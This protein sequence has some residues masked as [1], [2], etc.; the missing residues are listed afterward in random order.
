MANFSYVRDNDGN[1]MPPNIIELPVADSQTL[2]VGDAVVLSSNK[3]AK[4]STT[5]GSCVGIMAEAVTTGS[6]AGGPLA[7]VYVAKPSQIWRATASADATS[8]V[9]GAATFDLTSAQLVNVA[10]TTGGCIQI[11]ALNDSTTDI[12][13]RFDVCELA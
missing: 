2:V 13:I 1:N 9:L 4:G 7:K 12:L 3:I 10:D 8:Y 6:S 11:V 5:F